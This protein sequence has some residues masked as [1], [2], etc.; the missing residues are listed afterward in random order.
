MDP[1]LPLV[2]LEVYRLG[3]VPVSLHLR[4]AA[5]IEVRGGQ[6]PAKHDKSAKSGQTACFSTGHRPGVPMGHNRMSHNKMLK[7]RRTK[8]SG[9]KQLARL[10]KQAKKLKNA[11][12]G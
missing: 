11:N 10:A 3:A 7:R 4:P 9:R 12:K 6:F 5:G 1:S 8:A 2:G